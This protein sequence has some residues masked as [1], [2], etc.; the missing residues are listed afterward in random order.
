MLTGLSAHK[1]QQ[2]PLAIPVLQD[3]KVQQAQQGLT[4]LTEQPAQ[5]GLT[6][7]WE[8]KD[9]QVPKACKA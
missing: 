2:A 1:V 9:Q 6:A 7:H 3:L 5:Q 4:A 8:L